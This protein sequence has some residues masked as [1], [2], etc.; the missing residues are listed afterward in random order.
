MPPRKRYGA[1]KMR[2]PRYGRK[3]ALRRYKRMAAKTNL[4]QQVHFFKRST[5]LG[6]VVLDGS[7]PLIPVPL[8]FRL[9]QLPAFQEFTDLFDQY[10]ISFIK[11]RIRL[12]VSPDAQV[13]TS[14][15]Y[16]RVI[17]VRDH[18][19]S[20]VPVSVNELRQY[21]KCRSKV[22]LPNRD[23]IITLKPS[24]LNINSISVGSGTTYFAPQ[25]KKWVDCA[26]P[27]VNHLGIKYA[28]ENA[29][30]SNYV[31]NFQATMWF[32]CKQTR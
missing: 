18:D 19:D 15:V 32:Q 27:D 29:A 3:I 10:R 8:A 21:G 6:N 14:A 25:Y 17:Y 16:P 31:I 26:H 20:V 23:L 7:S 12:N 4:K 1:K 30:N 28:F 5:D 13:P 24:T 9:N 2:R 22:L 11:L